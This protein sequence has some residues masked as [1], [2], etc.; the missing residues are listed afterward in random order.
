LLVYQP[1]ISIDTIHNALLVEKQV[2]L[3][4][5]RLDKVHPIVSGN[6]LFKLHFFLEEAVTKGSDTIITF[7]GAYSNHLVATAYASKNVHIKS[8][9]FVRGNRPANVSHT[10]KHCEALGMHL[11]FL[12]HAD[13][14]LKDSETFV[15]GIHQQYQNCILIPE[16]GY[17]SSGA[18]G[19]ALIM[20]YIDTATTHICTAVGTATTLSGLLMGAKN[21]QQ[22]IGIPV[23][24]GMNDIEERV[25]QLSGKADLL[26]KLIVAQGYHFGGYAKKNAALLSFMNM[27]Y[28][29][30]H[31][32]TDFVYTA[33]ML[34]AIFDMIQNNSF[35]PGSRLV[36]IHTGGLQGNLSLPK[37][38]LTF[39]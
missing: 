34:F 14:A 18:K 11:H 25:L 9:G 6:K 4:V 36:C 22:I 10:L 3:S 12:S 19:A 5:L 1:S 32:P 29:Q 23:L 26:D 20:K 8:I 16:G 39:K 33:K 35:A 17:G 7:G 24:K 21:E 38:S 13:Y 37:G 2:S 15:A 28:E 30:Y 31:L 27:V